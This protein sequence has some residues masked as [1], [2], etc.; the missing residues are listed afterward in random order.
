MDNKR[1][2]HISFSTENM[3]E[4][5]KTCTTQKELL[6]LYLDHIRNGYEFTEEMLVKI[7]DF[8]STSKMKIIIEYNKCIKNILVKTI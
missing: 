5:I 7:A 3:E 2:G 8:D 4:F 6:P 1:I